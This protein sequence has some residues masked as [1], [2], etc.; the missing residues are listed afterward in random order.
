MIRHG[1]ADEKAN[2]VRFCCGKASFD[3]AETLLAE[4]SAPRIY[5]L[6]LT[7]QALTVRAADTLS[8]SVDG[9]D[10]LWAASLRVQAGQG[11]SDPS[12]VMLS[13]QQLAQQA[14]RTPKRSDLAGMVLAL[15]A[16]EHHFGQPAGVWSGQ[17]Q[18]LNERFALLGGDPV[19]R[20]PVRRSSCW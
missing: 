17:W 14:E 20:E 5:A 7:S 10:L 6:L 19:L 2:W 12:V 3:L 16:S 13:V 15:R 9:N 1:S 8:S 4:G 18:L 11:S